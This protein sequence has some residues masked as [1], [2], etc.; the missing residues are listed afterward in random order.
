MCIKDCIDRSLINSQ[1]LAGCRFFL[2]ENSV[3]KHILML[4]ALWFCF[5]DRRK[6]LSGCCVIFVLESPDVVPLSKISTAN[7]VATECTFAGESKVWMP[8]S[9]IMSSVAKLVLLPY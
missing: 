8:M 6:V 1:A 5:K 2:V 3:N 9:A 7:G 4:T